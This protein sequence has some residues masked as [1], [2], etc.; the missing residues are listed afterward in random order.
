MNISEILRPE[1]VKIVTTASSKKM[2]L[3]TLADL[4]AQNYGLGTETVIRA[5]QERENLGPTAVGRGVALPHARISD[6]TA[7]QGVFIRVVSPID[8]GAAD[9]QSVD[10][11]FCLLAPEAA[12]VEHLKALALV[13]RTLRSSDVCAKLRANEEAE[14]L[15]NILTE[16]QNSQVA[17]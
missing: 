16:A 2:L 7:V 12:G 10:L 11:F 17:A 9:R 5:L 6:V 13:S 3:H 4:A 1:A 8:F 15:F 14:T